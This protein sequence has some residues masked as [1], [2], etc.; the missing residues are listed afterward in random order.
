MLVKYEIRGYT[1]PQAVLSINSLTQALY[2]EDN[3]E[4]QNFG[5]GNQKPQGY[6]RAWGAIGS[7]DVA[8]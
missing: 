8:R 2:A 7:T 3:E 1:A 5:T 4:V 6:L